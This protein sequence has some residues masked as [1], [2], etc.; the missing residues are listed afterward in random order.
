[1]RQS[2]PLLVSRLSKVMAP[3]FALTE[4]LAACQYT[5]VPMRFGSNGINTRN[6]G[7]VRSPP[8]NIGPITRGVM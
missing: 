1:M 7:E 3:G 8:I 5:W 4:K 2:T 6:L